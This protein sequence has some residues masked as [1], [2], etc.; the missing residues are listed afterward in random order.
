MNNG[1]P[2]PLGFEKAEELLNQTRTP[3]PGKSYGQI[4]LFA[5]DG[6]FNVCGN[7]TIA[8]VSACPAGK[9]VPF[10]GSYVGSGDPET[11][12][13]NDPGYNLMP[14]RPVWQGQQIAQRIKATGT[15]I[16][17]VALTPRG[18]AFSPRG[19][20]EMSSGTENYYYEADDANAMAKIYAQI[21]QQIHDRDCDPYEQLVVAKGAKIT[22]KQAGNPNADKTTT[23]DANGNWSFARVPAGQYQVVVEPLSLKSPEDG[24]TREYRRIV[25]TGN[26]SQESEILV[27]VNGDRPN[28]S[29][30]RA[31][32]LMT[33]GRD[34]SGALMNGCSVP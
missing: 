30:V 3:P 11:Y 15:H 4:V 34:A 22:L 9:Y 32:V 7:Y 29:V 12:Y 13:L 6:V 8:G 17:V 2:G 14:G 26:P 25:N 27:E 24:L 5:T 1:T 33:M 19:L 16:F 31:G 10:D 28:G 23:T 21:D 18:G 20:P